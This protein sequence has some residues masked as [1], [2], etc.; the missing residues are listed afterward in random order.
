MRCTNWSS[1][2]AT[3]RRIGRGAALAVAFAALVPGAVLAAS[4]YKWVDKD[5]T[6]HYGD[7]PPKGFTGEVTRVEV[8]PEA[9]TMPPAAP[10]AE[11][12]APTKTGP[13]ILEQRRETRARLTANLDHARERLS[14]AQKALAEFTGDTSGEEQNIGRQVDPGRVNPNPVTSGPGQEPSDSDR[15]PMQV[16]TQSEP[17]RGGMLGMYPRATCRKAK[18]SQGKDILVCPTNVPSQEYYTKVQELED[19]VKRAQAE[20]AAAEVAYRKGVD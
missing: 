7:A 3:L 4:F 2:S 16:P 17:A 13:G 5:G 12:Q 14:L 15:V 11:L 19:A 1:T 10:S 6:V 9:H 20:V 18:N 8:D